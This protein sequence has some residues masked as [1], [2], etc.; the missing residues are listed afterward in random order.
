MLGPVFL[1]NCDWIFVFLLAGGIHCDGGSFDWSE[2][3]TT[4]NEGS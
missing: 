2:K 1:V 3:Q 4:E